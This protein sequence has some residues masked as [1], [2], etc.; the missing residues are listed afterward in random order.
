MPRYDFTE[1][2]VNVLKQL[3]DLAI[4]TAGLQVAEAGVVLVKKLDKPLPIAEV[5]KNDTKTT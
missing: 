3:I 2:E 5:A 4:K 1:Q